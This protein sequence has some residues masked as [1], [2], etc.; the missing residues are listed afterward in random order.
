M[1]SDDADFRP[2]TVPHSVLDGLGLTET[3]LE[4][5]LVILEKMKV[6]WTAQDVAGRQVSGHPLRLTTVSHLLSNFTRE[7]AGKESG[8]IGWQP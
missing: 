8:F 3:I 5:R 7:I 4:D 1:S 2:Q 6:L